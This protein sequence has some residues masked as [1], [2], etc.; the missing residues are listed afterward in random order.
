MPL[1]AIPPAPQ[2]LYDGEICT[3][4][5]SA[6]TANT[7]YF[8]GTSLYAP[9]TLTGIRV[10]FSTGGN[11]HYDIGIYDATGTNGAPGNL[12]AHAAATNTS[13][14]TSSAT[15][16]PAFINGNLALSPG[17]YWLALWVDN[18]TDAVNRQLASQNVGVVV[19]MTSTGPLPATASGLSNGTLKPVLVGLLSGGW[20]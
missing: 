14:V 4:S 16:T 15:L 13:L 3:T 2:A 17:R 18:S 8:I 9:A 5:S 12:L 11:G 20:S 7:V 19:V 6:V 1:F 10:R